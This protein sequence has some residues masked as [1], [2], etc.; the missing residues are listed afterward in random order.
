M[1]KTFS[2][3]VAALIFF[4][5][6]SAAQAATYDSLTL[7]KTVVPGNVDLADVTLVS[8]SAIVSADLANQHVLPF[9]SAKSDKYLAVHAKGLAIYTLSSPNSTVSFNWGTIDTYNWITIKR[10]DGTTYNVTGTDIL[11]LASSLGLGLT[12]GKSNIYVTL[13]DKA[14][15]AAISFVDGASN[16]F[17][18]SDISVVPLPAALGLFSA[19]LVGAAALRRR[20][21]TMAA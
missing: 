9:S 10:T 5:A 15:I 2:L 17:E 12:G 16:A 7:S 6:A 11:N 1:K 8:N 4:G 19:A 13:L 3:F 21:Q 18:I 14:G 20:K